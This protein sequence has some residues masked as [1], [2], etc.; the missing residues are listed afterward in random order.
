LNQ[1]QHRWLRFFS[2]VHQLCAPAPDEG[3][4]QNFLD[5][6]QTRTELYDLLDYDAG[7][8]EQAEQ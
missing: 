4:Q 1:P 3:T 2:I 7:E 6:M 8:F 5:Q